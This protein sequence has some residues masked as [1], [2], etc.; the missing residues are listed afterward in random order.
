MYYNNMIFTNYDYLLI[1]IYILIIYLN[2]YYFL[3]NSFGNHK[4][5]DTKL[6]FLNTLLTLFYL[7]TIISI[8][9]K[10]QLNSSI[11]Y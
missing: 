1:I 2:L 11:Y 9:E 7:L 6:I 4:L 8:I 10:N 3:L 5:N